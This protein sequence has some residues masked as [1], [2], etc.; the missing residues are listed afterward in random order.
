MHSKFKSTQP[1]FVRDWSPCNAVAQRGMRE[2]PHS[3]RFLLLCSC[4]SICCGTWDPSS[5]RSF[6]TFRLQILQMSAPASPPAVCLSFPSSHINDVRG[7]CD[8]GWMRDEMLTFPLFSHSL[9]L[10]SHGRIREFVKTLPRETQV[11]M[12]GVRIMCTTL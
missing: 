10:S 2:G 9:S 11:K 8:L 7:P 1:S 3:A 12:N 4:I 6:P 5:V